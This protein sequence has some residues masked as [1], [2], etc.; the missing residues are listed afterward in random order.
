MAIVKE[1]IYS[2][3]KSFIYISNR[4]NQIFPNKMRIAEVFSVHKCGDKQILN[5]RPILVLPQFPKI[6]E[7]M[8]TK[9]LDSF[10]NNN[11][12]LIEHQDSFRNT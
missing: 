9:S 10:L 12:I 11:H 2:I 4:F 8:F 6:V 1:V 3:I 7:N 5:Y